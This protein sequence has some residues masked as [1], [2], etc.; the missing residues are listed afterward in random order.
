MWK[1]GEGWGVEG[2][3]RGAFEGFGGGYVPKRRCQRLFGLA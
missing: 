2:N 1:M 3:G